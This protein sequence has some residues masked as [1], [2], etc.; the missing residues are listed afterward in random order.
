MVA[1]MLPKPMAMAIGISVLAWREVSMM[2][3]AKPPKVVK[4]ICRKRYMTAMV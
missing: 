4:T 1:K 3:G 2:I